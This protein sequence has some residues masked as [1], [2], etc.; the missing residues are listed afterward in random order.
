MASVTC[1]CHSINS[2]PVIG[3]PTFF[4]PGSALLGGALIGLAATVLYAMPGRIAGVSGI[5]NAALE[6]RSERGWRIAFLLG[7]VAAVR[8]WPTWCMPA[9]PSS[10]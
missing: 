10:S 5:V 7:L 6:Q 3:T 2:D 4:T 9:K 1:A 8:P